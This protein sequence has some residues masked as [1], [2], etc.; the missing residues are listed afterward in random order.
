MPDDREPDASETN[1]PAAETSLPDDGVDRRP[2]LVLLHGLGQSPQSWQTAVGQ[3]GLDYSLR[4][5]WVPGLKPIDT[6]GFDVDRAAHG[7]ASQLE[8]EGV[9]SASLVGV[10]VGGMVALR[11]AAAY[12]ELVERLL[13]CSTQAQ[14]AGGRL[15]VLAMK[16]VP[17]SR[18][19]ALG[20]DKDKMIA[21]L[22]AFAAIDLRG[23]LGKVSCPTWVVVG[24]DDRAGLPPARELAAGIPQAELRVLDGVGSQPNVEDEAGFVALVRDFM[25]SGRPV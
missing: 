18:F 20:V 8:L 9:R 5:P 1:A 3:L 14:P 7:L 17:R 15:Q 10:S 2:V 16:A 11:L 6:Q 12:P 4:C 25:A 23:D 13:L 22:Q 21:T 24:A 19:Q